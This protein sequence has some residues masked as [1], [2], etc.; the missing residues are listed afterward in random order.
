M[1]KPSDGLLVK[2]LVFF[3]IICVVGNVYIPL[4][5][6]ISKD[7]A[8][9]LLKQI[10]GN[11]DGDFDN[12][13]SLYMGIGHMPSLSACIIKNNSIVWYGGYGY[14]N[15]NEKKIPTDD[16]GYMIAS[17]SK[18][19]TATAILQLYEQGLFELDDNVS[20]YLPFDLKNPKYPN[21]NIT[22]RML[23]AHQSSLTK[24]K[25]MFPIYF[26]FLGY[27]FDWLDEY[28]LPNGGIYDEDTWRDVLPGEEYCYSDIGFGILGH[29]VEN[30]SNQSFNDYC[31]EHIFQPLNMANTSFQL[32]D[33]KYSNLA[34]P[35]FW[36]PGFY[37]PLP[38]IN[39]G[40]VC[41]PAG[42]LRTSI[43]DLSHYLIAH[44][45][46][47]V[48]NDRRILKNETIELMHS[49][50]YKNSFE[51]NYSYGLG[52]M[53][54]NETNN[55]IYGGHSGGIIGGRAE[56]WYRLSDNIGVIYFW[57][58]YEYFNLGER[59]IEKNAQQKIDRI[60][61]EKANKI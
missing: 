3:I 49:V 47:G 12:E 16:T 34:V 5:I 10:E 11:K 29:L 24:A 6:G 52:W 9:H 20:E 19:F 53:L 31:K 32:G 21:V 14:C 4:T 7:N 45:N 36:V 17:I 38:Q 43:S 58:Q 23:L 18:T 30:L 8:S 61:W 37:I 60:I 59:P 15:R 33:F 26:T 22:F 44:I 13:I 50:Q 27:S 28:L 2:G 48:Y 41:S 46:N 39:V 42:G 57:N 35:Y 25:F 51:Y 54:W 55:E 56:M 40:E 1:I